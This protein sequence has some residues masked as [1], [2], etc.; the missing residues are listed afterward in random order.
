MRNF[1]RLREAG[2]FSAEGIQPARTENRKMKEQKQTT[3]NQTLDAEEARIRLMDD[4]GSPTTMLEPY[5]RNCLEIEIF[6]S[7]E[8][9]DNLGFHAWH[10]GGRL[11]LFA[12]FLIANELAEIS[13]VDNELDDIAERY[14]HWWSEVSG[15]GIPMRRVFIHLPRELAC[16]MDKFSERVP[17]YYHM[18][19]GTAA[20]FLLARATLSTY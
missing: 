15:K 13:D 20:G 11:D 16:A 6:A 4:D 10:N 8:A 1:P 3:D 18:S 19:R 9:L 7:R 2:L 14:C 12:T 17:S 5:F